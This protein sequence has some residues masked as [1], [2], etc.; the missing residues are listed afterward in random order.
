MTS[1]SGP[2]RRRQVFFLSGFD[3]KG[4]SYYHALYRAEAARQSAVSGMPIEVGARQRGQQGRNFWI[5][6]GG[7]EEA[8]CETAYE[9][10]R[11]DDIVRQHWSRSAWRLIFDMFRA[12]G[13]ALG[14]GVIPKKIG[15]AHV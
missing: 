7:L 9:F 3:P 1:R 5:V 8:R 4:A 6:Q 13:M 14:S 10:A 11:W 12:Y 2:V 15:R